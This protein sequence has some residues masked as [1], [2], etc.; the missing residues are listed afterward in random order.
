MT[1]S[2]GIDEVHMLD[3]DP[4]T[5]P[6]ESAEHGRLYAAHIESFPRTKNLARQRLSLND[7]DHPEW[8]VRWLNDEMA[9]IRFRLDDLK[10]WSRPTN[11]EAAA[12]KIKNL[13]FQVDYMMCLATGKAQS[14]PVNP[15]QNAI[16]LNHMATSIKAEEGE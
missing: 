2:I 1:I 12:E 3:L 16:W 8:F 11:P 7:K 13:I 4:P 9:R 6:E 15:E 10:A 14:C 5:T